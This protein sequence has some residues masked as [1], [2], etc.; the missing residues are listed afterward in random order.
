[1]LYTKAGASCFMLAKGPSNGS[2]MA[3]QTT[4]FGTVVENGRFFKGLPSVDDNTGYYVVVEALWTLD[5]VHCV[6]VINNFLPTKEE[7][8]GGFGLL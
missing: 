6:C 2:M 5:C 8:G 1:M 3:W 7:V 4:L